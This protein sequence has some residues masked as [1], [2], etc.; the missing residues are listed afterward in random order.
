MYETRVQCLSCSNLTNSK[1]CIR[2]SFPVEEY[3][4]PVP[5][6][7]TDQNRETKRLEAHIEE[8]KDMLMV[9]HGRND[10]RD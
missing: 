2:D 7:E 10:N 5:S 4:S 8:K 9:F 6:S 1:I 3:K